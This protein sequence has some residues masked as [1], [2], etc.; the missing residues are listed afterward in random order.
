[1]KVCRS[2]LLSLFVSSQILAV[3]GCG[4]CTPPEAPKEV[5]DLTGDEPMNLD[6]NPGGA[7]DADAMKDGTDAPKGTDGTDAA[8]TPPAAKSD[9]TPPA[10]T[11]KVDDT[12]KPESDPPK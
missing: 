10:D 9:E 4:G 8:G 12:P 6:I 3:H 1:V 11:P 2:L 7:D 5:K